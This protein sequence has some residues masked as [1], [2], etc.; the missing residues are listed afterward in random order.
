MALQLISIKEYCKYNNIETYFVEEL[1][2]YDIV[3][4]QTVKRTKYISLSQIPIIEKAI[5][6]SRDLSVNTEGIHAIFSL[7]NQ[8]AQKEKEIIEMK[9]R[10]AFYEG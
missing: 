10:L 6:L 9:R 1:A 2:V 5:R 8:M 3:E 7:L 4:L